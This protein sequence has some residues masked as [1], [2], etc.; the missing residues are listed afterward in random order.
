MRSKRNA[1]RFNEKYPRL[2]SEVKERLAEE[3][4][5]TDLVRTRIAAVEV[6]NAR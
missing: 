3:E 5:L 4:R 6:K 2:V 1:E